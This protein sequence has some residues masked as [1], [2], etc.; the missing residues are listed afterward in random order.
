LAFTYPAALWMLR[1]LAGDRAATAADMVEIVVA[2][3]R[4]YVLPALGS[5]AGMLARSGE[6]ERMVAWYGR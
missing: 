3:E 6:L 4:G 2:L 5:A 1:W